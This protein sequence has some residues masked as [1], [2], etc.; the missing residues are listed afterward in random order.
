MYS[1]SFS[2]GL[3]SCFP[4]IQLTILHVVKT[5]SS[6]EARCLIPAQARSAGGLDRQGL[7]RDQTREAESDSARSRRKGRVVTTG[8]GQALKAVPI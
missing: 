8:I 3:A 6:S 5:S 2:S 1:W 4:P 7:G